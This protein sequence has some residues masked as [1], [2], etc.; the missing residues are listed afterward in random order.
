MGRTDEGRRTREG[1]RK[2]KEERGGGQE[3]TKAQKRGVEEEEDEAPTADE[4]AG[5]MIGTAGLEEPNIWL[6]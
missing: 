5:V 3:E 2:G 6:S 1:T 4:S